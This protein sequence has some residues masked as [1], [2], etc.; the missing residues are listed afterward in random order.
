MVQK[1][2]PQNAS[3][4]LLDVEEAQELST[5]L[6]HA[7][8]EDGPVLRAGQ[9]LPCTQQCW[10]PRSAGCGSLQGGGTGRPCSC[11]TL[12]CS[13]ASHRP[14]SSIRRLFAAGQQVQVGVPLWGPALC[15]L[16][17]RMPLALGRHADHVLLL[18]RTCSHCVQDVV[19]R[20]PAE[21][22]HSS[23]GS[24]PPDAVEAETA[25]ADGHVGLSL[26]HI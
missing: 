20:P 25:A 15:P 5:E 24:P 11:V 19:K 2:T 14:P 13:L 7:K 6:Q 22:A 8:A 23:R 17:G 4:C 26:I 9:A 18:A 10:L 16:P 3:G 1:K 21:K 12:Q